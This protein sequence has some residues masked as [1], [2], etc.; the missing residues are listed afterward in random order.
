MTFVDWVVTEMGVTNDELVSTQ[1]VP[2]FEILLS[3]CKEARRRGA[4]SAPVG[5][6]LSN[7]WIRL[8]RPPS[9]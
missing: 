4:S 6:Q 1:L 7:V 5:G 9:S 8:P 3:R 2:A